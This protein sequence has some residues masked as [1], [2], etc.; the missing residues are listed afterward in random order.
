MG[1][2]LAISRVILEAHDGTIW[3]AA[4]P[5]GGAVFS[6]VLP[7]ASSLFDRLL[8][9]PAAEKEGESSQSRCNRINEA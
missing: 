4:G 6:C 8:V 9:P 3:G 1:V 7:L 5:E 2:G